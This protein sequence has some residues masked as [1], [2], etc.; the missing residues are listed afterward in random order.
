LRVLYGRGIDGHLVRA[1]IEEPTHVLDLAHPAA[2][3]ERNENL[4][5]D[6][7]DNVQDQIALIRACRD[8]Q[9]G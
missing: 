2:D 9:K 3:G 4:R 6:L 5:R 1:G 7:L 8:V